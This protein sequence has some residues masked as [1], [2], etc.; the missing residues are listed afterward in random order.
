MRCCA[1][2]LP[3]ALFLNLWLFS[4][5]NETMKTVVILFAGF[6]GQYAFETSFGNFSA[7]DSALSW[8]CTVPE[9]VGTVVCAAKENAARCE[10]EA[11]KNNASIT[12]IEKDAWTVSTLLETIAHVCAERGADAAV[13]A[14]FD[15]P[16]LNKA[17]TDELIAAHKTYVAEY[18]FADGYPY[19]MTP[20]IINKDAAI[21]LAS[22]S[23]QK[24]IGSEIVK[25]D[26]IMSLLKTD[27]NSF[28][29]ET[30][31]A[32]KDWRLYRLSFECSTKAGFYSCRA[33]Y[34][35]HC[36]TDNAEALCETAVC[37]AAVLKTVP[38]FYNVH[39][40]PAEEGSVVYSPYKAAYEKK[41]G[42][43]PSSQNAVRMTL[44]QFA[45]L[46]QQMAALSE[47]AVV[48]LSAWGEPL[49][50]P[51]FVDF[52]KAVVSESGLSVLVE[53]NG[54]HVTESLC[55]EIKAIAD[56]KIIWIVTLDA[57]TEA[58]YKKMHG[59]AGTLSQAVAAVT[60]L[61]THFP[62]NVYPQLVRTNENEC[63][64][65]S[66]YRYWKDA[67]HG[68]N[69]IIQKYDSFCGALPDWKPADLSPLERN[70]CW[71]MRRDMTILANGD[72]PLCRE[73]LFDNI[74]GNAFVERLESIWERITPY[75]E[76][77]MNGEREEACRKCDEYYTFNF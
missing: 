49:L 60:L 69:V 25:R 76:R 32:P 47:N 73:F 7:Y 8:A 77:D 23:Q 12:L 14:A 17:V 72:V 22:L 31:L 38:A 52:V 58:L 34:D 5:D 15:C 29:I 50:H 70:P 18:T 40:E 9:S 68:G 64:L 65:E 51:Q 43:A 42:T 44:E 74:I 66:F 41:Y 57:A 61:Q 10:A 11:R 28:E 13:Y 35:S 67:A 36:N 27:I 30:V 2:A 33:V 24:K 3:C 16:F 45:P 39:I 63:E 62:E 6:S 48:S 46:V 37:L 1:I 4:A 21:I 26:S 56:G 59:E 20:E 54:L 53:T 71:H 55:K 75:V 19:G